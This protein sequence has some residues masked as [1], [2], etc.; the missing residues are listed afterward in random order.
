[1]RRA[2]ISAGHYLILGIDDVKLASPVACLSILHPSP[3][4]P[5][6]FELKTRRKFSRSTTVI[7]RSNAVLGFRQLNL[8]PVPGFRMHSDWKGYLP[9]PSATTQG[10]ITRY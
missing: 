10:N 1:M 4:P 6:N 2:D 3:S 8:A 9:G 5:Y 7:Q